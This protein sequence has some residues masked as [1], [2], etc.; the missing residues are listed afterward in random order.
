MLKYKF[1]EM[2][3]FI[4]VYLENVEE[5]NLSDGC[6]LIIINNFTIIEQYS[7]I[8]ISS[9]GVLRIV[10][11]NSYKIKFYDFCSYKH[12]E[13]YSNNNCSIYINEFGITPFYSR[14]LMVSCIIYGI[15]I[16]III[17]KIYILIKDI[18]VC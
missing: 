11:D 16:I 5:Y 7:D 15:I 8:V 18:R 2:S 1:E 12:K 17:I 6:Y 3:N 10:Y 13:S 4:G 9:F 14:I